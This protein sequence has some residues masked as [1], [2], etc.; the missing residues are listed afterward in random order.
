MSSTSWLDEEIW[1][2]IPGW[3]GLYQV[4]NKGRI[5]SLRV[6]VTKPF[7]ARGYKVATLRA[8][9]RLQ[10]SGVHR[11]VAAAFIPN[12]E[13]KEQ[14]NHINGVRDDNRVE[15]LEW[16]TCHENNLHRCRVL[17]GGGG[18][19]PKRPVICLTTGEWFPSITEA[20]DATGSQLCKIL[21]CCQGKRKHHHGLAW[22][23]AEEVE[24]CEP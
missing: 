16:V 4:S 11:F 8:G 13:G 1:R 21:L 15:N 9:D 3:E 5:R 22:A 17:N 20:A 10:R 23:Y 18:G 6:R 2:D 7:D 12:P 14:V 19:R 24:Q